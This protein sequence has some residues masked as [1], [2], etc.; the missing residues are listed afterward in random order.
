[1][2]RWK[3]AQRSVVEVMKLRDGM[4]VMLLAC[5]PGAMA[6]E[7]ARPNILWITSE[8]NGQQLGAMEILTRP[9]RTSISWRPKG[10]AI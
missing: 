2:R 5:S 7:Q 4:L 6:A 1:M 8:D 10:C 3:N 9:R